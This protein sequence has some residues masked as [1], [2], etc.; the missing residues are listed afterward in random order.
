MSKREESTHWPS[1]DAQVVR[2]TA[3]DDIGLVFAQWPAELPSSGGR[4]TL[5]PLLK[6]VTP[7]VVNVGVRGSTNRR[8]NPL[9]NAPFFPPFF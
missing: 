2:R 5:S 3:G 7:A 6:K 8:N 4:A 1:G 9:Y